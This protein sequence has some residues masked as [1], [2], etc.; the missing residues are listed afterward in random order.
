MS[1][2][3]TEITPFT[4]TGFRDL[5]PRPK[6]PKTIIMKETSESVRFPKTACRNL[7]AI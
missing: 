7:S 6:F 4:A 3:H 1:L 5:F 2:M